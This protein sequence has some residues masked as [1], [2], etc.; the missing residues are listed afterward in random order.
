MNSAQTPISRNSASSSPQDQLNHPLPGGIDD[1]FVRC[2][3]ESA[4]RGGQSV[5]EEPALAV[6]RDHHHGD[7]GDDGELPGCPPAGWSGSPGH[8][9]HRQ[10]EDHVREGREHVGHA[11]RLEQSWGRFEQGHDP[12]HAQ[13][14]VKRARGPVISWL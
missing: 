11:D 10:V 5:L 1:R 7:P 12:G 13:A 6:T 9:R 4:A 3:D 8:V 2:D 14:Q